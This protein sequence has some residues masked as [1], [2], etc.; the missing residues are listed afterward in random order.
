M[1]KLFGHGHNEG[2]LQVHQFVPGFEIRLLSAECL[3]A[4]VG[5]DCMP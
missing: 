2:G 5:F 4:H 3:F 1:E